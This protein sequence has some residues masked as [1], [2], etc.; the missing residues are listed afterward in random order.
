MKNIKKI[1]E[2]DAGLISKKDGSNNIEVVDNRL[3]LL[4]QEVQLRENKD[5]S[6]YE[7]LVE[8]LSDYMTTLYD[9]KYGEIP[10]VVFDKNGEKLDCDNRV[11]SD[12]EFTKLSIANKEC[13]DK[14]FNYIYAILKKEIDVKINIDT[15]TKLLNR[16]PKLFNLTAE[17]SYLY[18]SCNFE[19][20]AKL[21]MENETL[22][23]SNI[24]EE[25][26]Y[27]LLIDTCQLD[28]EQVF[29]ALVS[30]EQFKKVSEKI[31]AFLRK[32]N[33]KTF[34]DVTNI[35]IEN[36]DPDFDRLA[37][38]KQV[39]IPT[40]F[41]NLI[42]ELLRNCP[43]KQDF[44]L[45]HQVLTD[46]NIKIDYGY[47]Y[48]DYVGQFTL[49]DL[50]AFSKNK[51]IIKD[52]L[53]KKENIDLVYWRGEFRMDLYRLYAV[54]GEYEKALALFKEQYN[55]ANDFSE[56]YNNGFDADGFAYGDF[57]Y[58]DSLIEFVND[59]CTSF[60]KETVDYET[61]KYI[62]NEIINSENVKYINLEK[63]LISLQSLLNEEDLNL[64]IESFV[65]KYNNKQLH[66]I[67]VKEQD[68]IY[69]GYAIRISS[70]EE[71]QDILS[72][73]SKIDENK[74]C[75]SETIKSRI[76]RK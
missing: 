64:L 19:K 45:I 62:I 75:Y 76:K 8:L 65:K 22:T 59:V 51:T 44:E 28:N 35:I 20:M 66:F 30:K 33:P 7:N 4:N 14:L 43:R 32:C 57:N 69:G 5:N 74:L 15:L 40:Y 3:Y 12:A 55:Y 25:E 48:S 17:K 10:R 58:S 34:I 2:S 61:I 18:R 68:G 29:K 67:N 39:S 13:A 49:R 63:I 73:F 23:K 71:I 21:L 9:G 11:L 6:F 47:D 31:Y 38:I 56:D 37:F 24:S 72:Q 26:I 52:L 50:I 27:K 36:Y 54:T 16:N 41:E 70:A 1:L 46:K 60:K 53:S 42:I